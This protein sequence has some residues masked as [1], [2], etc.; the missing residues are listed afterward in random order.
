MHWSIGWVWKGYFCHV[1]ANQCVRVSDPWHFQERKHLVPFHLKF[2]T[3]WGRESPCRCFVFCF[4]GEGVRSYTF[5]SLVIADD[6]HAND[7]GLGQQ[8]PPSFSQDVEVFFHNLP[9][10]HK[11]QQV[12]VLP[13]KLSVRQELTPG[14]KAVIAFLQIGLLKFNGIQRMR[15]CRFRHTSAYLIWNI[16]LLK[17]VI[18]KSWPS[19]TQNYK[20]YRHWIYTYSL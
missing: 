3:S 5:G 2:A 16:G 6:L 4:F 8:K 1:F 13:E 20:N 17:F 11:P 10:L 7:K 9:R 14:W 18:C 12:Q 15:T 19:H